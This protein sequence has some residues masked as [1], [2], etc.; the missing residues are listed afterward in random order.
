MGHSLQRHGTDAGSVHR[1][2]CY[3]A[4]GGD[5]ESHHNC[6]GSCRNA[7][8][9]SNPYQSESG[10]GGYTGYNLNGST[11]QQRHANLN[12]VHNTTDEDDDTDDGIIYMPG[13]S[14]SKKQP[15]YFHAP[16]VN[17]TVA[18]KKQ[19]V[20]QSDGEE[21]VE[22]EH[23][24]DYDEDIPPIDLSKAPSDESFATKVQTE[25]GVNA[26]GASFTVTTILWSDSGELQ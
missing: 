13:P 4:N 12:A 21:Q 7:H 16:M 17:S 3:G 25:K 10:Y 22:Q 9:K 26:D 24:E 15:H 8:I 11:S 5:A 6:G 14:S 23:E 20:E 2:Q 18:E 19:T 1:G